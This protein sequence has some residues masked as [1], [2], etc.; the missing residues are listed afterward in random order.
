M[1]EYDPPEYTSVAITTD[2]KWADKEI[3]KYCYTFFFFQLKLLLEAA[4]CE[5]C[6]L[7]IF[8]GLLLIVL[9]CCYFL[10]FISFFPFN[11][12]SFTIFPKGSIKMKTALLEKG[13]LTFCCLSVIFHD[14]SY[15]NISH[16]GKSFLKRHLF[17]FFF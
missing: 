11:V 1:P 5:I 9:P 2:S 17:K 12:F 14:F 8:I 4:M 6:W 3:K 16:L 13:L 15:S 7:V 10:M